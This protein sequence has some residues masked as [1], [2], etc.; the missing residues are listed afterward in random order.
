MN[1]HQLEVTTRQK[2]V[3]IPPDASGSV[4][5]RL[6]IFA[7]WLWQHRSGW[8]QP[9][10]ATYKSHLLNERGLKPSSAQ[11]HIAT[12]RSRYRDLMTDRELFYGLLPGSAA[13]LSPADKKAM[14][15]ELIFKIER[16]I[17]DKQASVKV[18]KKQDVAD[19]DHVRLTSDQ[20]KALINSPSRRHGGLKGNIAIR[21]TAIIALLLSTGLRVA[22]LVNVTESDLRSR[23]GGELSLNVKEGKG[24][25]ARQ[26]VY[27][28][29]QDCLVYVDAWITRLKAMCERCK[30]DSDPNN[31]RIFVSLANGGDCFSSSPRSKRTKTLAMSTRAVQQM[32]DKHSIM[33]DGKPMT[34][35]PHDLRRT[36]ARLQYEAGMTVVAIQQNLGHDNLKTTLGY[37]GTLDSSYRRGRR[38]FDFPHDLRDVEKLS[39]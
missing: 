5:S 29:L 8:Y 23:F 19:T 20:A 11:A 37:I 4:R 31:T 17:N 15:D 18:I 27:G 39:A 32:L 13:N 35:N 22:E 1:E 2:Q 14:V 24:A 26:V 9:N 3:I 30:V 21:D 33:V 36:Y 16:E 10:L 38:A 6:D 12:I 34:V 28:E 7:H 25:K